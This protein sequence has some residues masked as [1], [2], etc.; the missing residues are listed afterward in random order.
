MTNIES[1]AAEEVADSDQL[2]SRISEL[3][4]R[5][6]VAEKA[7]QMTQV[8]GAG[9]QVPDDLREAVASGRIGSIL[10]EVNVEAINELQRIAVEESR[11]GIPLLLARDVIHGFRTVLPIPL[12]LAATFNPKLVEQGARMAALEAASSGINWTFAPMIDIS[13]DARWGR[14]AESFGEDPYLTGILGAAMVRGFQ[15]DGFSQVGNIAATAKHFAGYGASESG[16]DYNTT[17]IPENELR[18][19]YLPPFR[20]L[21]DAGV[22]T[23]MT[24]FSD[25]NGVP[26]TGNRFLLQQVLRDE[27]KFDG[28]VVSDWASIEELKVHGFT[29]SD[30]DSTITAVNAGVNMDMSSGLYGEYLPS[31]VDDGQVALERLDELVADILRIKFRLGL[32]D[33]PYTDP[34]VYPALANPTHLAI[35]RQTALESLVLLENRDEALPLDR[36]ALNSLA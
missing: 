15:G 19:V 13:R 20:A 27:W 23:V 18:N 24:S 26:A 8:N 6:T 11:L 10:N 14:I 21:V 22:A 31:A 5:M 30:L 1:S 36:D 28:F 17:N 34:G 32:F 29:A 12:G 4:A 3:L 2:D 25:L 16:R 33:N 9:G 7:G 35:A